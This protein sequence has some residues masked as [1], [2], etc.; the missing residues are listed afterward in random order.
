MISAALSAGRESGVE[1]WFLLVVCVCCLF[2]EKRK[3]GE[4]GG[5]GGG[6]WRREANETFGEGGVRGNDE[7]GSL[8]H[9]PNGGWKTLPTPG[10]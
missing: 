1:G 2:C 8:F 6:G 4:E 10:L 5:G 7:Q 9:R 3:G